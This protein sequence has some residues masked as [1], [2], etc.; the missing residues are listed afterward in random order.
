MAAISTAMMER[1]REREKGRRERK[2][3]RER[4][5]FVR[6][7]RARE[8]KLV[9]RSRTSRDGPAVLGKASHPPASSK[10]KL[11]GTRIFPRR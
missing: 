4:I 1:K 3:E 8:T 2:R 11:Q 5:D 7:F 10:L 9:K 6:I